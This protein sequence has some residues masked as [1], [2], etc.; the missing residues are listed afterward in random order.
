MLESWSAAC[1]GGYCPQALPF[2]TPSAFTGDDPAIMVHC[3]CLCHHLLLSLFL[4]A[5]LFSPF[6][7]M[8]LSSSSSHRSHFTHYRAGATTKRA[9]TNC[10]P[11]SVSRR[12][13]PPSWITGVNI[14]TSIHSPAINNDDSISSMLLGD[15]TSVART[16][17]PSP[18]QSPVSSS[19]S[20]VQP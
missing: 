7:P 13:D 5:K 15:G 16:G 6:S 18:F 12:R 20:P 4:M 2:G 14:S 10:F 17:V 11:C 19:D 3:W 8:L 9:Q 1:G